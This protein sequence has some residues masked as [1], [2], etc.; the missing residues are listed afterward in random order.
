MSSLGSSTNIMTGNFKERLDTSAEKNKHL[1]LPKD[2]N[3][4]QKETIKQR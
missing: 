4:I 1:V 3:K 2:L